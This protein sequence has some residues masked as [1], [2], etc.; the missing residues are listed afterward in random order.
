M[1]MRIDAPGRTA[2]FSLVELLVVIGIIL[3]LAGIA[4]PVIGA[5][6][7]AVRKTQTTGQVQ[8]LYAA[9]EVYA[10]EDGRH[11]PPP[12]ETDL[13]LRTALGTSLAPRTL[14]LLRDR[15]CQW[16]SSQLGPDEATGRALLDAWRRPIRYQPDVN[17]DT[18]I[19]KPAAQ[20]DWNAK[21]SEPF[22]YVWSIGKPGGD[23][24][25]DAAAANAANW[26]YVKTGP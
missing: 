18:V 15:G 3:V 6:R 12:V 25:A 9:C 17:M 4:L 21:S 19:D 20:A 11:L 7:N 2:G 16:Q 8:G 24:A 13:T 22:S 1:T 26:I 10:I 14:D 5:V 23:D